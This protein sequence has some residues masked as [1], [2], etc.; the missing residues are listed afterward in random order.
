VQHGPDRDGCRRDL[1]NGRCPSL[2]FVGQQ[3][4]TASAKQGRPD[5]FIRGETGA[6]APSRTF[7]R[8][9][10]CA[11]GWI[12]H[13]KNASSGDVALILAARGIIVSY[14]SIRE[15]GLRFG[16]ASTPSR[17]AQ[18]AMPPFARGTVSPKL[19]LQRKIQRHRFCLLRVRHWQPDNAPGHAGTATAR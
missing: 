3:P 1:D 4:G 14:E 19:R 10:E 11:D 15:W 18:L 12:I 5:H 2:E 17:I 6:P 7:G 8:E 9:G 13:S 16:L